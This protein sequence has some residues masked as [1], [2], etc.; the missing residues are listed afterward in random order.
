MNLELKKL[1]IGEIRSRECLRRFNCGV[2]EIDSW[3]SDKAF[4]RHAQDRTRVFCARLGA[5][6]PVIGFYSLSLSPVGSGLLLGQH[7]DRYPEGFAPF[8]YIDRLAVMRMQQRNG[9]GRILLMNALKRAFIVSRDLPF[10][11]VALRSLNDR[12][13]EFYK[14]MGFAQRENTGHPLMILPIWTIRDLFQTPH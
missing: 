3:A 4:R 11:G 8:V 6:A 9:I 12:T 1:H 7:A 2:A 10:Y 5:D 13:T 14:K